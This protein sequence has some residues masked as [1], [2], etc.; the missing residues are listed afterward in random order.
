[1]QL[2]KLYDVVFGFAVFLL[3]MWF[4]LVFVYLKVDVKL[5][6]NQQLTWYVVWL[7]T[8]CSAASHL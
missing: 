4:S 1:M 7:M 3:C 6:P 8:W 2:N 5:S